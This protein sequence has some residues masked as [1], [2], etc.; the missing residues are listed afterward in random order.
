MRQFC[1]FTPG[2]G[3]D[4]GDFLDGSS[5][6]PGHPDVPDRKLHLAWGRVFKARNE[7][8]IEFDVKCRK[9]RKR[10][11]LGVRDEQARAFFETC[12][13]LCEGCYGSGA[14]AGPVRRAA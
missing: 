4:V 12:G 1:Q 10:I 3:R 8:M 7:A 14:E 13:A 11:T 6:D 5:S 2:L 9:C